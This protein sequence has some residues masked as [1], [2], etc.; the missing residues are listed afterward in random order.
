VRNGRDGFVESLYQGM[1]GRNAVQWEVDY[2]SS[3]LARGLSAYAVAELVWGSPEHRGL[4]R[5]HKA[6]GFPFE[7]I[8]LVA[9]ANG[10]KLQ[11]P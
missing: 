3:R 11:S 9:L 7:E 4:L 1:L 10:K 5:E 8:Y 2:W 6:P